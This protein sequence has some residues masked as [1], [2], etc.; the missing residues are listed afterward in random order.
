MNSAQQPESITSYGQPFQPLGFGKNQD[1]EVFEAA[2][3][4]VRPTSLKSY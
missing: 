3:N 2:A 1:F 4:S